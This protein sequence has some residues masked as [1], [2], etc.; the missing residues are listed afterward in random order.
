MADDSQ[1]V[2]STDAGG[3]DEAPAR[4]TLEHS[5]QRILW[6]L[7]P[8]LHDIVIIGGWVPYLYQRYGSFPGWRGQLA[9][10][11]EVD[12]LVS[13]EVTPGDRPTIPEI[14]ESAG[15][16]PV[17]ATSNAAVWAN[18][19]ERG[20]KVEFL[21]PHA[22]PYRDL[23][24]VV[25]VRAQRGMGAISLTALEVLQQYTGVLRVVARSADTNETSVEVRVPLLGAYVL[26]KA[27]TFQKR[28][29]L[30]SATENSRTAVTRSNPKKAKD[31][32]YLRDLM[33]GGAAIVTVIEADITS[34]LER[35]PALQH[36]VDAAANSLDAATRVESQPAAT[37]LQEVGAMLSERE[38]AF[39]SDAATADVLGH[40]TDLA[41]IL[42]GFRS[43]D[44]A[45]P[46]AEDDEI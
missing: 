12:V 10:T 29:P 33:H 20:E 23:G 11:A 6:E 28:S 41:D 17:N 15:F 39:T 45:R 36:L 25:P 2:R 4:Q 14:L 46:E 16:Q 24:S 30:A 37:L 8:Y 31:L 7:R 1:S 21:V 13:R 35:D 32:L 44:T 19:P 9:L 26:N 22:G 3:D 27:A 38:P 18:Q 42:L 34:I 43:S 5:L 40:L